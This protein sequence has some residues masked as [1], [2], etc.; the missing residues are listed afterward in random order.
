MYARFRV[1]RCWSEWQ[2][3]GHSPTDV[4]VE[5]HR[6]PT[7]RVRASD[8]HARGRACRNAVPR[9]V[10]CIIIVAARKPDKLRCAV[11]DHI[12]RK[13]WVLRAYELRKVTL[14]SARAWLIFVS[15]YMEQK[16]TRRSLVSSLEAT[17]IGI[18][19]A[20]RS[21]TVRR[22]DKELPWTRVIQISRWPLA[23]GGTIE[24]GERYD[25]NGRLVEETW[26]TRSERGWGGSKGQRSV[27][28]GTFETMRARRRR[29][30]RRIVR[31]CPQA[32]IECVFEIRAC[33][34]AHQ[35]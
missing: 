22:V 1:G 29:A 27:G 6:R 3:H 11:V 14:R 8:R 10:V 20:C 21:L 13:R 17:Q 34:P 15:M 16:G 12:G 18:T 7:V 25:L 30:Y 33:H 32:S 28:N 19:G 9:G 24:L 5:G 31:P 23:L 4:C 2:G 35:S 26:E